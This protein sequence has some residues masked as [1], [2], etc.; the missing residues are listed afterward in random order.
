MNQDLIV[1]YEHMMTPTA[2]LADYVLP[3]DSW[4]ER[5]SMMAGLSD[6]AM[7]PPGECKD[8]VY[9]WINFE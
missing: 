9:F 6:Q 2:E 7:E 1:A 4:L 3:G 5:P 8:F